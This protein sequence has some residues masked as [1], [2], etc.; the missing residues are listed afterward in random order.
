VVP[1][2]IDSTTRTSPQYILGTDQTKDCFDTCRIHRRRGRS[3]SSVR[4]IHRH[5]VGSERDRHR[6]YRNVR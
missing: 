3:M 4:Y 5:T 2:S 1:T 6:G